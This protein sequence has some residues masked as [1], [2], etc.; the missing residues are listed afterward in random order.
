MKGEINL[1]DDSKAMIILI[2]KKE[3]VSIKIDEKI[4]NL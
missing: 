1:Q 3:L 2:W 4:K